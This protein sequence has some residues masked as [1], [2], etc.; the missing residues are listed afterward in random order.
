MFLPENHKVNSF[1]FLCK[2]LKEKKVLFNKYLLK[3]V[4]LHSKQIFLV[5]LQTSFRLNN[6]LITN[7]E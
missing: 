2:T 5:T 3:K 6:Y 7:D 1:V 4:H